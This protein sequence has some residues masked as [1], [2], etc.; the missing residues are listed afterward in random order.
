MITKNAIEKLDGVFHAGTQ[1]GFIFLF[2][3]KALGITNGTGVLPGQFA[4][5]VRIIPFEGQGATGVFVGPRTLLTAAH[6]VK[7]G[8]L[9]Y[10]GIPSSSVWVNPTF[11]GITGENDL[12]VVQFD[13]DI[14]PGIAAV[15]HS[16]IE[17][18]SAFVIV[19]YGHND[20]TER[21]SPKGAGTKRMGT[22]VVY[23]VGPGR[24][25]FFGTLAPSRSDLVVGE[26]VASAGGDS[27]APMFIEGRVV[28]LISGG[29]PNHRKGIAWSIAVDLMSESNQALLDTVIKEG[30]L[31]AGRNITLEEATRKSNLSS[32]VSALSQIP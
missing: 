20:I 1:L 15:T 8:G 2:A 25:S 27:G 14:A 24:F 18:G 30:V 31:I 10:D 21:E 29:I 13:R 17:K 11:N 19:G 9:T 5:V 23:N 3:T 7:G 4:A 16:P 12:A 32:C 26:N 22:N 6:A 28:G